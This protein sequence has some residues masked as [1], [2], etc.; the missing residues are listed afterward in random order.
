MF[1]LSTAFLPVKNPPKLHPNSS[2]YPVRA[3][4]QTHFLWSPGPHINTVSP[5][6]L[7]FLPPPTASSSG[8]MARQP[9]AG[10]DSYLTQ[11]LWTELADQCWVTLGEGRSDEGG[12]PESPASA[13]LVLQSRQIWHI[14][15]IAKHSE[16]LPLR[17]AL[18][19][20]TEPVLR[21]S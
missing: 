8:V 4:P 2:L 11:Q 10:Q 12:W 15:T 16:E 3:P 14:R 17:L 21:F 13:S 5:L 1:S 6:S 7:L 18:K 9:D 19:H 20:S